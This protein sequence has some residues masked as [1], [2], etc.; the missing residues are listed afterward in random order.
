MRQKFLKVIKFFCCKKLAVENLNAIVCDSHC[1]HNFE[2]EEKN[3]VVTVSFPYVLYPTT[4]RVCKEKKVASHI[5]E[6]FF[7]IYH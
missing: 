3:G 1:G 7:L 5:H 6:S 2:K 4:T